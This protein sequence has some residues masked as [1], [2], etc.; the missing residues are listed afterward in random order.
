LG[1]V[2]HSAFLGFVAA[3]VC[4][5]DGPAK[6]VTATPRLDRSAIDAAGGPQ[7]TIARVDLGTLGG[8]SSYAT[9]ISNR[10]TV[11]GWSQTATGDMHAFLWT[12]Q[13]GMV[14]LGTLPG[15]QRSQAFSIHEGDSPNGGRILGV[16]GRGNKWVPVM[17]SCS[18]AIEPLPIPLLPGASFGYP[19][20]FNDQGQVVGWDVTVLQHAW[21]WSESEG[22][23]DITASVPGG[24][25]GAASRIGPSGLVVGTNH[26]RTCIRSPECW[27]AFLWTEGE[28]YRDLGT[29]GTDPNV[30]VTGNDLNNAGTVVGWISGNGVGVS[31]Y[32]WRDNE[33]FT[34]LPTFSSLASYGYATA[35]NARGTVV[36]ASFDRQYG[37]IQAAAWPKG[38]GIVK[39]S[40]DDPHPNIAVA[41]N[42][43]GAVAGW[44]NLGGAPNHATLW[45]L[46]PDEGLKRFSVVA[47]RGDAAGA[48]GSAAFASADMAP[49]PESCLTDTRALITRQTLFACI[50]DNDQSQPAVS[51]ATRRR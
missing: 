25:E 47:K 5:C 11:V 16:S 27:H 37:A 7:A 8:Q 42:A 22:K 4:A 23:Y 35:V 24:F 17:W 19:T 43:A 50:I 38:G 2:K 46:G 49:G 31:P 40:P 15:D 32:R 45:R 20:D 28:G 18:G 30:N 6:V 29:P 51:A 13:G 41:V 14:D 10:G 1:F 12:A 36:G 39:L 48:P 33:G 21:I 3:L 26:A 44:S 34:V 9:D